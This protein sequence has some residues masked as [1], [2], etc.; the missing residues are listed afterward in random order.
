MLPL[1]DLVQGSR[2]AYLSKN[3]VAEATVALSRPY[4]LVFNPATGHHAAIV[5][6][7][8]FLVPSPYLCGR[9]ISRVGSLTATALTYATVATWTVTSGRSGRLAE[10][11]LDSTNFSKTN[12]QLTIGGVQQWTAFN[13]RSSLA[14]P[15]RDNQLPPDAIVLL[16]AAST[17][18]TSITAYGS[19]A[20]Q[21]FF[22]HVFSCN[23]QKPGWLFQDDVP[24]TQELVDRGLPMFAIITRDSPLVIE[25]TN[26]NGL[27]NE[28]FAASALQYN[29]LDQKRLDALLDMIDVTYMDLATELAQR[30]EAMPLIGP[31]AAALRAAR[32]NGRV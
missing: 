11:S 14:I 23:I 26:V 9:A 13:P 18:G 10:I 30:I 7:L 6:Q 31:C 15:F 16:E 2:L 25:L 19:I 32:S 24:V 20:G 8:D 1:L 28:P 17:D 29:L 3:R 22:D 12:W 5:T 27:G 21:E 4:R